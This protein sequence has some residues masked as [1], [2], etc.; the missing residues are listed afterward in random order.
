[1]KIYHGLRPFPLEFT[2]DIESETTFDIDR[3]LRELF[4]YLPNKEASQTEFKI[5]HSEAIHPESEE[6]MKKNIKFKYDSDENHVR[7]E[8]E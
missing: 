4:F 3:E 1:M 8:T 7:A 6:D 2:M 5:P